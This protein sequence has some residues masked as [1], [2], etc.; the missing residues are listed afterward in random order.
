[1]LT[2]IRHIDAG[3]LRAFAE[4]A[5]CEDRGFAPAAPAEFETWLKSLWQSGHSSPSKCFLAETDG[6]PLAAVVYWLRGNRAHAEHMRLPTGAE[7]LLD[8][9]LTESLSQL[10]ADGIVSVWAELPTPP[11]RE[12]RGGI[13]AACLERIGFGMGRE[14]LTFLWKTCDGAVES[15]LRLTFRSLAELGR[16]AFL[17]ALAEMTADSLDAG[18]ACERETKGPARYAADLFA[19]EV[20]TRHED[21]WWEIGYD[22]TGDAVGIA[23]AGVVGR[24]PA[25]QFVAVHPR[26][27]GQGYSRD[28]LRRGISKLR[29]TGAESV[30]GDVDLANTPMVKAFRAV[31]FREVRSC[32]QFEWEFLS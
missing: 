11:L 16:D 29:S 30:R 14:R 28:L 18:I 26:H 27:R 32:R 12:P 10:R 21:S 15:P 31:G 19:D 9:L 17:A 4:F 1:M 22:H 5:A 8:R 13:L 6:E 7:Q 24:Q 20:L 25:V 23:L 3:E 2:T